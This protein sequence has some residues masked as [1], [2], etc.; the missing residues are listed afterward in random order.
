[1][2]CEKPLAG[3][4]QE[5]YEMWKAVEL[6]G[7][8]NRCAFM[9]RFIPAIQFARQMIESGGLGEVRTFRSNFLMNMLGPQGEVS[10]R[11]SRGAA[12]LGALGD[13][14]SHHVDL[15]RFLVGEITDV[16]AVMRTW[17][18]D[19]EGTVT[20][21]ND[22]AFVAIATLD[23]GALATFEASRATAGHS[24]TGRFEVDGTKGSISWEMERLNEIVI[25]EP[26]K[27]PRVMPVLRPGH[28]YDGFWLPGGVQG[29]HPVGWNEC[30]AHQ[31]HD[32]LGLAS[33]NL[34]QSVAAS[35]EDGYHVAEIIDTIEIA[36][37]TGTRETVHFR[38]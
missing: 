37:R 26:G 36:A 16:T 19:P 21:I 1:V 30:F 22:D 32:I 38:R 2:F 35:F 11:F 27:G 15:A 29:S 3:T 23:N 12:G 4:A 5:A 6:A 24:L 10:W 25:R 13:L 28:P 20:D 8:M 14:G 17:T 31:A 33:G 9:H 18:K 34:T 7:V